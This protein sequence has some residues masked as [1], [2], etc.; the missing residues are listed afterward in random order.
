MIK[1][2]SAWAQC[3]ISVREEKVGVILKLCEEVL[4][5]RKEI[6]SCF[7]VLAELAADTNKELA[8]DMFCILLILVR[9]SLGFHTYKTLQDLIM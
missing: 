9:C 1:V 2:D 6:W 8:F 4:L 7:V 5:A 3:F